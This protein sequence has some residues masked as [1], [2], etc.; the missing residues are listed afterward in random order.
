[1]SGYSDDEIKR[2]V[3]GV[4]KELLE[5]KRALWVD[6]E[7][8][9]LHHQFLNDLMDKHKDA[10]WRRDRIRDRVLGGV[11]ISVILAALGVVGAW[12]F[13]FVRSVAKIVGD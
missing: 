2:I 6:P 9:H 11:L 7:T 13:S 3:E 4:V 5:S 10:E 12:G 8:H 1:M